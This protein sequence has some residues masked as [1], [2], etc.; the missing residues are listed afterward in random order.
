MK[1]DILQHVP[2][3]ATPHVKT[4]KSK[5]R[6]LVI[7]D[8]S[9][10]TL[11][12]EWIWGG[13]GFEVDSFNDP[14]LALSN[15]SVG[16]YDVAFIDIKMPQMNGLDLY[17]KLK[18]IDDNVKYCFMTAYEVYYDTL[19]RNYPGLDVGW[20]MKKPISTEQLVREIKSRL[21]S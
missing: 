4:Q 20:F 16:V 1:S 9:D 7:D 19:K 15:F 21:H 13:E 14:E 17:R 6:I 3:A 12:F 18:N 5:N 11:T 10:L 2:E 8:E